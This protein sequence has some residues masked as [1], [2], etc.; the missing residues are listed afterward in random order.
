M[1]SRALSRGLEATLGDDSML[2][3]SPLQ[4]DYLV[5]GYLGTIGSYA[6]GMA[7]T[8]W[9]RAKGMESPASYWT[10]S[11]PIRRF[12]RD[13][14]T[15]A[16]YTRYQDLFYEGLKEADRVYADLKQLE[17]MGALKEDRERAQN[18]GDLLRLRKQ[19]NDARRALSDINKRMDHLKQSKD[20]DADYKQRELER[21]RTVR[22]RITEVLG[23]EV[24]E[25]RGQASGDEKE[26]MAV[27]QKAS[28][29]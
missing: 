23:K 22:N 10:E 24:E 26:A 2:T 8:M 12:Y 14:A 21:L 9:R 6:M 27:G 4:L 5:N 15:P 11:K 7:D 25:K 18:K 19:L 29:Q 13:L 16:Y 3:L 20:M 1:Q 17:E 28:Q